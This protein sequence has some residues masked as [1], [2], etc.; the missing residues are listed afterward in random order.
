MSRL[1]THRLALGAADP[2]VGR[3]ELLRAL[4]EHGRRFGSFVVDHG[5][6]PLWHER[7][8]RDEFRDSR[9]A[10]EALYLAQQRALCE[11][12]AALTDAGVE[13]ALIKGAANRLLLYENP[14]LRACH[15]LD[16]LVRT[17]DRLRASSALM[18]TG[19]VPE[20]DARSISREIILTR[21]PVDIDLHWDLLRE[22]RLR[23]DVTSGMLSR[24]R[25]VEGTWMLSGDDGLFVLLVH[26]AFAKHLDSWEMGLHR[27]A[28]LLEW[29]RR[30]D[31]DWPTVRGR[32]AENGVSSAAWATLRWVQ[33]L[34]GTQAPGRLSSMLSDVA[35]GVARSRW[36]DHWLR[37]D[38][39]TRTASAHWLRLLA[40]S[41]FLHDTPR[42]AL[43]AWAGR[44]RAHRRTKADLEAFSGLFSQ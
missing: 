22:G 28:D 42:D 35:P 31:F 15:D 2:A 27:V 37:S 26:P 7:T 9:M 16:V 43:R 25:R 19:F 44:R 32:L 18:R 23:S 3:E 41:P 5:L 10:V 8:G 13:Y 39:S 17:E 14:A 11:A 30:L 24:R 40:F 1:D 12:D 20:P 4:D 29:L 6:G 33:L 21:G 38:L 34:A 36:L